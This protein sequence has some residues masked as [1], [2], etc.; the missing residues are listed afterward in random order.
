MT[1][2][3]TILLV[4]DD[5]NF[6]SLV[7][8]FL[9]EENYQVLE[10][11]RGEQALKLLEDHREID[12]VLLD[13]RLP[14][15][16]GIEV[17]Q[18]S[19][20]VH[21]ELAIIII[22]AHGTIEMAVQAV[23]MGA[24][25]FLEKP[26]SSS[27][28]LLTVQRVLDYLN[29]Q[30]DRARLLEEIRKQYRLVCGSETM[31]HILSVIDRI[32]RTKATVLITGESGTG[33]EIVAR[34]IH[35]NSDR[36]AFP[37]VEVNCAAIPDNLVESE[38]FGH[39][40][41]AFT[42]ALH[43]HDGKFQLAHRG[44]L[45]LDEIGDLSL[46]AQAKVLRAIETCEVVK[47]GGEKVEKIDVRLIVATHQDL[48]QKIEKGEFRSDLYHRINVVPIHIPPLRERLDDIVPLANHFLEEFSAQYNRKR[49]YLTA[50][51]KAVLMGY[52]WPGNVRELR[53]LMEKVVIFVDRQ[54]IHGRD[55]SKFLFETPHPVVEDNQ[56]TYH[57]AKRLF[58]RSF[59]IDQLGRHNWNISQTAKAIGI[60]RSHLYKIME[61]LNIKV[62]SNKGVNHL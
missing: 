37:F 44:T 3:A 5:P 9:L 35:L 47:V 24:Y 21:P 7:K 55:I 25:D 6:R 58:E 16:D 57:E 36:A 59:L 49:P 62:P 54:D 42:G 33:K 34:A 11:E 46:A 51:A 32:A 18:R 60:E 2:R 43:S 27:R 23:K 39:V 10:C 53:N 28:L 50:D 15:M 13:L 31:K 19:L 40:K 56:L 38:L 14:D 8:E 4:E 45:F 22:S 12:L 17:L 20:E 30:R 41:G 48:K 26:V 61:R 1:P 52:Q 29:V